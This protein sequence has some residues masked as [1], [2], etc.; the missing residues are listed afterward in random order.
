MF[1]AFGKPDRLSLFS[2]LWAAATICHS[3][4]SFRQV[5]SSPVPWILTTVFAMLLCLRPGS[6]LLLTCMLFCS[7][8]KN[9]GR[10]PNLSDHVFFEAF[11]NVGIFLVLAFAWIPVFRKPSYTNRI[12]NTDRE[13]LYDSFAPMARISLLTLYFFVVLH[14]LNW[15]FLNP[16]TSCGPFLV[17]RIV[18]IGLSFLPDTLFLRQVG[19]YG[20]LA[21]EA[22]IPIL[23]CSRKTYS[24]G[25]IVGFLF[26][27]VLTLYYPL[28]FYSFSMMLYGLYA[29]FLPH[30]FPDKLYAVYQNV[31]NRDRRTL[32]LFFQLGLVSAIV[33]VA[34]LTRI[35]YRSKVMFVN[36][37]AWYVWAL[38]LFTIFLVVIRTQ[39]LSPAPYSRYFYIK[40][41][42]LWLVPAL[43]FLNGLTPYVGLKTHLS[44]S[45][46]SNLRTEGGITNHLFMPVSFRIAS[47]ED[48]LVEIE[49]T[50]FKFPLYNT[51][52]VTDH[53]HLI[54]FFELRLMLSQTDVKN[55]YVRYNRN[56][57]E[58]Y[59]EVKNGVSSMPEVTQPYG[60]WYRTFLRFR[61][62]DKGP[63]LCKH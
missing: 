36:M 20:T 11:V 58:Y 57:K 5:Y 9:L 49:D 19:V 6:V 3:L 21:V 16:Q 2:F 39:Q 43:L 34:L 30:D 22:G 27:F 24:L 31:R 17:N 62:I 40:N 29:L 14:K 60:W 52:D 44:F 23:L 12:S 10:M 53:R 45:M 56:G 13:R 59:L 38:A 37:G 25:V 8:W 28:H 48:D 54:P 32:R 15:D 41:K 33:I 55:Y 42:A 7:V 51:I 18:S 63:C 47:F 4:V 61:P 26:H 35:H 50:N 1:F 46:Y